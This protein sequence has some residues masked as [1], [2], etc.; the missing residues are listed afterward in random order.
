M[1]LDVHPA[2]VR[3]EPRLGVALGR[4]ALAGAGIGIAGAL[5]LAVKKAVTRFARDEGLPAKVEDWLAILLAAVA[6]IVAI[7]VIPGAAFLGL[8]H[9]LGA[10]RAV[11][12]DASGLRVHT[13]GGNVES[14]PWDAVTEAH[15]ERRWGMRWRFVHGTRETVVRRDGFRGAD[16]D[17]LAVAVNAGLGSRVR[18]AST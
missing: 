11:E 4:G 16:W 13:R 12:A 5:V 18:A 6:M 2:A 9:L 14:V 10:P 1:T 8:R 17:R 3:A 7:L 15:H